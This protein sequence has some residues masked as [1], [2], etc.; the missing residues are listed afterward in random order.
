MIVERG[1]EKLGIMMNIFGAEASKAGVVLIDEVDNIAALADALENAEGTADK[2]RKEMSAGVVG[3]FNAMKSAWEGLQLALADSGFRD[4]MQFWINLVGSLFRLFIDAPEIIRF[5]IIGVI[6]AGIA[7]GGLATIIEIVSIVLG[8]YKT[9]ILTTIPKVWAWVAAQS[10]NLYVHIWFNSVLLKQNALMLLQRARLKALALWTGILAAKTWLLSAAQAV[11]NVIA[12][13]NPYVII[14]IAIIALI[15]GLILLTNTL[16]GVGRAI[17]NFASDAWDAIKSAFNS[18]VKGISSAINW[19]KA[20]WPLVAATLLGPIGII[21]WAIWKFH[22]DIIDA[23]TGIA[24]T[25]GGAITGAWD[26]VTGAITGGISWVIDQVTGLFRQIEEWYENHVPSWLRSGI[27]FI[28]GDFSAAED[29]I[30]G[31][32]SLIGINAGD[33]QATQSP[34]SNAAI[35]R[36]T[37]N[38]TTTNTSNV[39]VETVQVNVGQG[40]A[41]SISREIG[42]SLEDELNASRFAFDGGVAR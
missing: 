13:M 22:D 4:V 8:I 16:D 19:I 20:N 31:V 11:F 34:L 10:A 40:D 6:T 21:T 38:V 7:L 27:R 28:T 30:D 9:L 23:I 33:E 35:A 17:A 2:M 24:N 1:G 26:S 14:L 36:R 37:S 42:T 41:E 39:N 15:A 18:V 12:A 5:F 3:A 32:T 25:I 29:V